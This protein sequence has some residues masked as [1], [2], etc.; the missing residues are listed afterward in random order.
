MHSL[1]VQRAVRSSRRNRN[2]HPFDQHLL[3]TKILLGSWKYP[4]ITSTKTEAFIYTGQIRVPPYVVSV[5]FSPSVKEVPDYAFRGCCKLKYLVPNEGLEKIGE[6]AFCHCPALESIII[7]STVVEIGK[8]AFHKCSALRYVVLN[9]GLQEIGDGAFWCCKSLESVRIPSSISE[10]REDT[11]NGCNALRAV[12]MDDGPQRIGM[13]AFCG[14]RSLENIKL[15]STIIEIGDYVFSGCISVR[16]VDLNEGLQK[17]GMSAFCD[18]EALENIMLPSTVIEIGAWCFAFCSAL[19]NVG[20]NEGLQNIGGHAFDDYECSPSLKRFKLP[21]ATMRM[22]SICC[23]R[24]QNEIVCK[25][26]EI[27]GISMVNGEI[28]ISGAA[29]EGSAAGRNSCENSLDQVVGLITYHELKEATQVFELALWKA[30][31]TKGNMLNAANRESCR[32]EV[33]GTVKEAV[34]QFFP[35]QK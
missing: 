8:I 12:V 22:K 35:C 19:K 16:D 18:C 29:L 3:P 33:P 21:R 23:E 14:C 1:Q 5:E 28:F 27:P 6:G 30:K 7:P 13:S 34:Q 4:I 9:D 24:S 26:L 25:I 17:I 11:F 20:L 2:R 32:V 10:I 31:L 15:P